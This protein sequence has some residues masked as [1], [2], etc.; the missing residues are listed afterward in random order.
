MADTALFPSGERDKLILRLQ[1]AV[2][3]FVDGPREAVEDADRVLEDAIQHLTAAL[4]ERRRTIRTSWQSTPHSPAR[5]TPRGEAAPSPSAPP[6]AT[7]PEATLAP[8][9]A[10]AH[11]EATGT[12]ERTEQKT[13]PTD[14]TAPPRTTEATGATGA[15][16]ATDTEQLRLALRD[17]RETTERLLQV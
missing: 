10:L 7:A 17:Y 9:P 15:T 2:G 16:G 14:P 4:A 3:G 13:D 6:T 1:N 12:T 8:D 11:K 5:E